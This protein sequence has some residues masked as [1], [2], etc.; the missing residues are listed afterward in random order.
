MRERVDVGSF[1]ISEKALY[2]LMLFFIYCTDSALV[3]TNADRIWARLAWLGIVICTFVLS[4]RMKLSSRRLSYLLFFSGA[5]FASMIVN[6][7][8]DVNCIQRVFLVWLACA[9]SLTMKYD[10]FMSYFIKIIRFIAIFSVISL[11]LSPILLQLPL[12]KMSIGSEAGYFVNLLFT[13]VSSSSS[14]NF[15]PFW[16]PGAF[17]LYLNW[18]V[19]YEVRHKEVLKKK[20][21]I[22]FAICLF[23]TQSTAGIV[24]F[25]LIMMYYLYNNM[26]SNGKGIKLFQSLIVL[27]FL[28]L[29]GAF[30][31][32]S[33]LL[34]DAFFGKVI[35]LSENQDEIN[36]ANV[37]SYTRVYSVPANL[38]VIKEHPFFGVGIDQLKVEFMNRYELVSNTASILA[39]FATFGL[40]PGILYFSLFLKA[41]FK[42]YRPILLNILFFIILLSMFSTENMI[43]SLMFWVFLFYESNITLIPSKS[44]HV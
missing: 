27:G 2:C 23:T 42:K 36:S 13:N 39:M 29:V 18:A 22:I 35:A 34:M 8:F 25:F 12:P 1:S 38:E 26:V 5:I 31:A 17:Q 16:E 33:E 9:I 28:L 43:A 19:L 7:G 44:S 21:I 15:G 6:D 30:L 4:K 37:S 20:D 40:I 14:R 24:I 32:T 10:V 41:S 11:L 3:N